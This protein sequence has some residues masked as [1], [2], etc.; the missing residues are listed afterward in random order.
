M[1]R[2]WTDLD[3]DEYRLP[4]GFKRVGYDADER[5]HYFRDGDGQTWRSE[6]GNE[7]GVFTPV[8]PEPP[9]AIPRRSHPPYLKEPVDD[10]P[11]REFA[12][13]FK[14]TDV[15]S[16]HRITSASSSTPKRSHTI[17]IPSI[18]SLKRSSTA[19]ALFV[20]SRGKYFTKF[21]HSKEPPCDGGNQQFPHAI[22]HRRV[23]CSPV[24]VRRP[25]TTIMAYIRGKMKSDVKPVDGNP[26]L[27]QVE[28]DKQR[29]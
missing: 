4:E 15:L 26:Q 24:I 18:A 21:S 5:R 9:V 23:T 12:S 29:E 13:T 11:P 7:Y 6:P 1:P 2:R 19:A 8:R 3:S 25:T 28:G 10:P 14:F 17:N 22:D 20:R 27:L 16:S